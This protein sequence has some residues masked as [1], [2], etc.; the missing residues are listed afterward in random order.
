MC[1]A[2]SKTAQCPCCTLCLGYYII[3]LSMERMTLAVVPRNSVFLVPAFF[4]H[5][6]P[7]FPND[8][9]S[10]IIALQLIS[11]VALDTVSLVHIKNS[12]SFFF[13]I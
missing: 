13:Q 1:P 9:V 4:L 11:C 10:C 6:I 2:G 3:R 7:S 5:F 8:L 12:V